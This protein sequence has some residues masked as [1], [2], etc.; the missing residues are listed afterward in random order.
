ML[1]SMILQHSNPPSLLLP[2]KGTKNSLETGRTFA[3][4]FADMDFRQQLLEASTE[5]EFKHLI[6]KQSADLANEQKTSNDKR[7]DM[8]HERAEDFEY[9]S[10]EWVW[11]CRFV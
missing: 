1:S 11:V 10:R 6:I 2:Q 3:T 4:I 9:V 5:E 8:N 7:I